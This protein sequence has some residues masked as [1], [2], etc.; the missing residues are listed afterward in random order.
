MK[1]YLQLLNHVLDKGTLTHNRTGI[2]TLSVFGYQWRHNMADGFPLLTTK[3]MYVKAIAHELIWFLKGSKYTHY[4]KQNGITIWDEW[5][6]ADGFVG[7]IYGHQWRRWST[8]AGGEVDQLEKLIVQI[9]KNPNSRRHLVSAWN[10]AELDQM[11][12]PPCHFAFQCTVADDKLN[13]HF[14]MRSADA[15]LGLPFDIA[16][17]AFL[18]QILCHQTDLIPGELLVSITDLHIYTNHLQQVD[19]QLTREPLPLPIFTWQRKDVRDYD[20]EILLGKQSKYSGKDPFAQYDA[21][22]LMSCLTNYTFHPSI[23]APVAV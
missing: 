6:K 15:F 1:T 21:D 13:L 12:I 8:T 2:D 22:E 16:S 11:V 14:F 4:L 9:K 3:K 20:G 5:A 17:Y 7:P 19:E 18:L 10:V 23:P